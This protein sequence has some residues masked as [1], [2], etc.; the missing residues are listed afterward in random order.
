M[1]TVSRDHYKL[2]LWH[3][4]EH[5]ITTKHLLPSCKWIKCF[6]LLLVLP[7]LILGLLCEVRALHDIDY[8][9]NHDKL[10]ELQ[11]TSSLPAHPFKSFSQQLASFGRAKHSVA[12]LHLLVPATS[13]NENLC[14]LIASAAALDYPAPILINWAEPESE[15]VYAQHLAKVAGTLRYLEQLPA[16]HD[17]DL[18]L[19]LDGFD[20]Q[21]QLRPDMLIQRYHEAVLDQSVRLEKRF[22]AA[23]VK[24]HDIRNTVL[25]GADKMCWPNLPSDA[26]CWAVPQSP[27]AE[28]LYGPETDMGVNPELNR[29]RWLNSGTVLGPIKD[30]RDIMVHTAHLIE[31][32]Y[33]SG[34]DQ[35]YIAHLWGR[36]EYGRM[37]RAQEPLNHT[38]EMVY[39][40][41][42]PD[43]T[44]TLKEVVLT[45]PTNQ[46][47]QH[48]DLHISI[49]Y[50][51]TLF[52]LVS[53]N[54]NHLTWHTFSSAQ[55]SRSENLAVD[56]SPN[57]TYDNINPPT[58]DLPVDLLLATPPFPHTDAAS[59][60]SL[61]N[62]TS[63]RNVTLGTHT[64]NRNIFPL[65]HFT[66]PKYLRSAWFS[67]MWY[68]PHLEKMMH[69]A[70]AAEPAAYTVTTDGRE[71]WPFDPEATSREMPEAQRPSSP[72]SKGMESGA[73]D[74]R[75]AFLSWHALCGIHEAVVF[76]SKTRAFG[77]LRPGTDQFGTLPNGG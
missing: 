27:Q 17:N 23:A 68:F 77:E 65:L 25:F 52:Q 36:Q 39:V 28:R 73:Y 55:S 58:Y 41:E 47:L 75:A 66:G 21:F 67:R 63:W 46:Q 49:D 10:T 11:K 64:L 18:V 19:I 12:H 60:M 14:R 38:S 26:G 56:E 6:T 54:T 1:S 37:L 30:V 40:H 42:G 50:E 33:V 48:A 72:L 31:S 43:F 74:E 34:S 5:N 24:E 32:E 7:L 51:S 61:P 13:S 44:S 4:R 70:A 45:V 8:S 76:G 62:T 16:E 20:V 35:Y 15:D 22:G 71:W 29:P 3:Q 57:L 69:H 9:V 53:G 59:Y 2:P